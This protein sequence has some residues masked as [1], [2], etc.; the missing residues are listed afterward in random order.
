M[1]K[2]VRMETLKVSDSENNFLTFDLRDFLEL[3]ESGERFNWLLKEID[4]NVIQPSAIL[5]EMS[6]KDFALIE[7]IE[8][9]SEYPITWQELNR[10]AKLNIQILNGKII[11]KYLNHSI[12]LKVFD[13]SY[14]TV[15]SNISNFMEKVKHRFK[16][17]TV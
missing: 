8:S 2:F 1:V 13:G 9:S 6:D 10:L 4:I 3:V 15:E 17:I 7:L 5:V 12:S 11:G 14:W 16:D